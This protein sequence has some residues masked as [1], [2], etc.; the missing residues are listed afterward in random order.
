MFERHLRE[1]TPRSSSESLNGLRDPFLVHS[2]LV[3]VE[4]YDDRRSFWD[5]F[6]SR[7]PCTGLSILQAVFELLRKK[8]VVP[9]EY[10]FVRVESVS[11]SGRD[12][13]FDSIKV[14]FCKQGPPEQNGDV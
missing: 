7:G 11:F 9:N 3:Q 1:Q 5:I 6:F 14:E 13:G 2:E 4:V 8:K 10:G 12:R